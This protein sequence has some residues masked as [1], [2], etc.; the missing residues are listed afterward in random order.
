MKRVLSVL[1]INVNRLTTEAAEFVLNMR[2]TEWWYFIVVAG[3]ETQFSC[4]LAYFYFDV[5]VS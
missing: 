2:F 4:F 5:G 1:P 3:V